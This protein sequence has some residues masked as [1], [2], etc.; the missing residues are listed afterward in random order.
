M[1]KITKSKCG[2]CEKT[3][4]DIWNYCPNCGKVLPAGKSRTKI[5]LPRMKL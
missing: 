4:W 1:E 5:V 2:Q 3:V